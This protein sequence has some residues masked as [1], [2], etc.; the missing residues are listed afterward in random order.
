MSQEHCHRFRVGGCEKQMETIL[1]QGKRNFIYR[2]YL[3]E[4][5]LQW[6]SR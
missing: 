3:N 1:S 4:V 5:S 2:V 6:Q